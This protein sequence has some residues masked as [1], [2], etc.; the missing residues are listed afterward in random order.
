[1]RVEA[2]AAVPF[3]RDTYEFTG[4]DGARHDVFRTAAAI[5]LGRLA[6]EFRAP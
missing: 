1:V 5:P 2:G 4:P 6:L 3:V